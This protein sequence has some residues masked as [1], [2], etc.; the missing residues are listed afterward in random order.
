MDIP[1]D[2]E[3]FKALTQMRRSEAD[4]YNEVLR[5]LLVLKPSGSSIQSATTEGWK[6]KGAEFPA[7]TELQ[8]I[9]RGVEYRAKITKE[10]IEV[11]GE[12][13][14]SPSA[15]AMSITKNSVNGWTFWQCRRPGDSRWQSMSAFRTLPPD[16]LL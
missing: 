8:S 6:S 15:A 12:V 4:S 2:F 5:R 14:E 3:V 16:H 9:Y 1:V 11:K 13:Y 7:G 10:G